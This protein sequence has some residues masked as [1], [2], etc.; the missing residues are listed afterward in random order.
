MVGTAVGAT[1]GVGQRTVKSLSRPNAPPDRRWN[2]PACKRP[3]EIVAL[4]PRLPFRAG[5]VKVRIPMLAAC[6]GIV[7]TVEA[8]V[9][10]DERDVTLRVPGVGVHRATC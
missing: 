4:L 5:L 9:F 8:V 2:T 6:I 10:P 3:L 7:G 1:L